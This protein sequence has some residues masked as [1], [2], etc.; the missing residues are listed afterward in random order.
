M[1]TLRGGATAVSAPLTAP[2]A[3]L[4]GWSAIV[5]AAGS[6]TRMRSAVPK[7]LHPV[8]GVP[9]VRLA[10]DLLR[11]AGCPDIVVV[12]APG[13]RDAI[14]AAVGDGVRIAVQDEPRGTAH[15]VLAAREVLGEHRNALLM[16]A[17]MPLLTTRTLRELAG[18]HLA[19]S[20]A[21]TFLTAYLHE[22][23][24]YDRVSRRNG[25]IQGITPE[26]DLVGAM[27]GAPEVNAGLYAAD[28]A[29]LWEALERLEP[30]AEGMLELTGLIPRAVERGG[31]EVYQVTESVEVQQVN[32]RVQLAR[33]E[34]VMRDR[35]R[36][37][38]MLD[39]VTLLDPPSTFVDAGV[40]VAPDT[41]LFPG[42]Y[43]LGTTRIGTGCQ[44]G[45][46]AI[47]RDSMIADRCEIG[48]STIEGSEIHEGVSI[49][50]YCHLRPGAVLERDVHLGNYVEVKASRIGS[51]TQVGHFSYLGDADVGSGVNIG[52]GSITVNY[53]GEVK[54]RTVI[55]DGA[56]IGSDSMLIA[57]ISVGEGA[58][59]AAG[60][61]VTRDVPDGAQVMGVPARV[62]S[63]HEGGHPA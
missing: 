39:G 31:V 41:T 4:E 48:A 13:A 26:H 60:S 27:R 58:R 24:G 21:L 30:N 32:D 20:T 50:P 54:H 61:V 33:A 15:A 22:P 29:W 62:R 6:G 23:A 14:A 57:P 36:E 53:D 10:C 12:A 56:F 35:I 40:T 34:R 3:S 63:G 5:L 38:L 51:R 7:V 18:R 17:N 1:T 19:A 45:P 28:L 43:L 49:G 44:V 16:H 47:V 8:A 46:N 11:A 42:V 59:T 25:M 2:V 55:G 37:R 9:M 52:A